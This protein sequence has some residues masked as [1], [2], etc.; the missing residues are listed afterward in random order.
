MDRKCS[1]SLPG[2]GR[3]LLRFRKEKAWK[4][5]D[6]DKP[7]DWLNVRKKSQDIDERRKMKDIVICCKNIKLI[8]KN[9]KY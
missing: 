6:L 5:A 9:K 8:C 4:T 7:A 1:S 3:E 2:Y